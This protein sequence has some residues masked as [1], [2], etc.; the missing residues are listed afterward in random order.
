MTDIAQTPP[1]SVVHWRPG[2]AC[3]DGKLY[4]FEP[5]SAVVMHLWPQMRA[6]RRTP[7]TPWA[8]TRR[9]AD[10]ILCRAPLRPGQIEEVAA[11]RHALVGP[12]SPDQ[13][14]EPYFR[15]AAAWAQA[16]STIPDR[17]REIASSFKDRRWHLLAMM[18]RCPGAADLL[19]SNPALGFALASPWVLHQPPVRQPMRAIR[20][21]AKRPQAH[22]QAW[23]GFPATERV[24][25]I[26]RRID[27][28]ALSARLLPSLRRGLRDEAVQALLAHLPRISEEVLRWVL[29]DD[30]RRVVTPTLLQELAAIAPLDAG[31]FPE[32]PTPPGLLH[33]PVAPTRELGAPMLWLWVDT[34]RKCDWLDRP[35]PAAIRSVRQ[36]RRWFLETEVGVLD[37]H[38]QRS[39]LPPD[40]HWAQPPWP[41]TGAIRPLVTPLD[42]H[43]EGSTMKHCVEA[44]AAQVARGDYAVYRVLEPVRATLGLQ[45]LGSDWRVD[46]AQA[47]RGVALPAPLCA[48]IV[49]RLT[50]G[51]L[52]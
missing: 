28:G 12:L 43:E 31:A 38:Q 46:Q 48:E 22:I 36:L 37:R 27:P 45:R 11:R 42:L 9:R 20:A 49:H 8:H 51:A 6:W 14:Y 34:C 16:L 10:E 18:A 52:T 29:R 50:G 17:E 13:W 4:H 7:C 3:H 39:V 35:R 44:Y 47:A 24:R 19:E 2:V 26:L 15:E 41:G 1:R 25:R 40:D 5:R 33:G 30:A 21:L 32:P 23:L